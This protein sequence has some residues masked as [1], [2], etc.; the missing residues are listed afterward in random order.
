MDNAKDILTQVSLIPT[1]QLVMIVAL[2][3][4]LVSGFAIYAVMRVTTAKEKKKK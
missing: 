4:V 3:A 2:A 1:E